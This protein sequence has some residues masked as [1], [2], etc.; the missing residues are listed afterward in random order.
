M[1]LREDR[2]M[3]WPKHLDYYIED[4]DESSFVARDPGDALPNLCPI[5][6]PLLVT[7][8]PFLTVVRNEKQRGAHGSLISSRDSRINLDLWMVEHLMEFYGLNLTESMLAVASLCINCRNAI[9]RAADR[10]GF[11]AMDPKQSCYFCL[12]N[13]GLVLPSSSLS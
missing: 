10:S 9:L 1:S 12:P 11:V 3:N 7:Q 4:S 6:W 2:L 13:E 5:K 8:T